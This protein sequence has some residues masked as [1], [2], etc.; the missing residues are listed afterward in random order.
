MLQR[1]QDVGHEGGT[2]ETAE[3]PH[4]GPHGPGLA[5]V[6]AC[7][8]DGQIA[9]RRRAAVLSLKNRQTSDDWLRR[10]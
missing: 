2:L 9:R 6:E 5:A 4:G 7:A 1:R 3:R 8:K 10:D